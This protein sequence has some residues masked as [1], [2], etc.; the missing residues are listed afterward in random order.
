MPKIIKTYLY[1]FILLSTLPILL[2]GFNL[3][4]TAL[5][6]IINTFF[7]FYVIK[8]KKKY[9]HIDNIHDYNIIKF[10]FIWAIICSIRGG[11]IAE[12]YWEWKNLISNIFALM[13]PIFTYFFSSPTI[14]KLTFRYWLK[15]AMPIFVFIGIWTLSNL[16]YQFHAGAIY[17]IGCFIPL[18]PKKW[19]YI[20][21]GLLFFLL[22]V[23]MGARSQSLKACLSLF[24][25]CTFL[26]VKYISNKLLKLIMWLCY[27]IPIGL[28]GLGISGT[29]NVFED[30]SKNEGKFISTS[31]NNG[32]STSEDLSVDTRTFIYKEV[33]NSAL[34]NN[35]IIFGRTPARGN[36]S[37]WFGSLNAE[38]LKTG[39]YERY[40]NELCHLNI[41][42]WTGIIGVVLYSLIY[43]KS[44]YLATYRSRNKYL[45]IIGVFIAFHWGYGWIEDINNFDILTIFLWIAIAMGFSKNF[46]SMTDKEFQLWFKN[47]FTS[48]KHTSL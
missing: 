27:I 48:T 18:M 36:D 38:E 9:I 1:I 43:L 35:Y 16:Q 32:V 11:F 8:I 22:L 23:N 7:I 45:K 4:T 2:G 39:K 46:R 29:F 47:I 41:F 21:I 5:S 42:T 17:I 31:S 20:T 6:W 14:T 15:Y 25:S 26:Y 3:Y 10:F 37:E 30:L 34:N 44:S 24:I 19:R 33:I 13:L 12:N 28:V 40:K